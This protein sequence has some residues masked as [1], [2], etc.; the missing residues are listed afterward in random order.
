MNS[1]STV[2]TGCFNLCK[3]ND[4]ISCH[5]NIKNSGGVTDGY[6]L[7][8]NQETLNNHVTVVLTYNDDLNGLKNS[9]ESFKNSKLITSIMVFV[10]DI[11]SDDIKNV[12]KVLSTSE[13]QWHIE[14]FVDN[15]LL[16]IDLYYLDWIIEK[17]K[18][19][20]FFSLKSGDVID[21]IQFDHFISERTNTVLFIIDTEDGRRFG[22]PK[23]VFRELKGNI[24]LPIVEKIKTFKDWNNVCQT[25][26]SPTQSLLR[27]TITENTS[28]NTSTLY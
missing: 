9:I 24:D 21:P 13:K 18:T 22:M 10:N 26:S 7:L 6:C 2:C 16:F 28:T 20:I 23:N 4:S 17:V 12:A 8:K 5:Q 25:I 19:P 27:V 15:D 1:L 14:N 3:I 11:Q